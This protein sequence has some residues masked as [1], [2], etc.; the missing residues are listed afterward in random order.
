MCT[1]LFTPHDCRHHK[2]LS[3]ATYPRIKGTRYRRPYCRRMVC[4]DILFTVFVC[5]LS[6]MPS[7]KSMNFGSRYLI[8]GL[9]EGDEIWHIDRTTALAVHQCRDQWT[10]AQEVALGRQNTEG[11]K[12]ISCTTF[13]IHCLAKHNKIRLNWGIGA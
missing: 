2:L 6:A 12:K 8:D 13:L 1:T 5:V 10:V 3:A 4:G 9:S 11:C 7:T